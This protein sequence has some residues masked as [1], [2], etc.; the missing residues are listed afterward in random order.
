[1]LLDKIPW[2]VF[3]LFCFIFPLSLFFVI[4][5]I[6][7]KTNKF[8][9]SKL[10][11]FPLA[12][13]PI[14]T[15][16]LFIINIILYFT[17]KQLI[18]SRDEERIKN[19]FAIL[20]FC[21]IVFSVVFILIIIKKIIEDGFRDTFSNKKILVTLICVIVISFCLISLPFIKKAYTPDSIELKTIYSNVS[22]GKKAKIMI[23]GDIDTNYMISVRYSSGTS[24]ADGLEDK[25]TNEYGYVSWEWKVGNNTNSGKYPITITNKKTFY[26]ETFYFTVE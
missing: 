26:S 21:F 19:I 8:N 1:M 3:P 18:T 2:Y 14:N 5:F 17:C 16:L 9:D 20:L 12:L 13:I 22:P 15:V 7:D 24:N 10:L 11:L 6:S 23:R 25:T 4:S